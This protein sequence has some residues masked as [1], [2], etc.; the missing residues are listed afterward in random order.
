[1]SDDTMTRA[2]TA[3]YELKLVKLPRVDEYRP[4]VIVVSPQ[5]LALQESPPVVNRKMA[6]T[7]DAEAKNDIGM[8][9]KLVSRAKLLGS[10]Y[11]L[12]GGLQAAHILSRWQTG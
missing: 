4:E 1:M 7:Y 3:L 12:L 8:D 5:Y 2:E 11:L 9:G 10:F 6:A